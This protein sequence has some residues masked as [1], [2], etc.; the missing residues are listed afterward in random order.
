MTHLNDLTP[1]LDLRQA[2]WSE[3]PARTARMN[4]SSSGAKYHTLVCYPDGS[5]KPGSEYSADPKSGT[6]VGDGDPVVIADAMLIEH[7]NGTATYAAPLIGADDL[8]Q[9]IVLERDEGAEADARRLLDVSAAA[10]L[11]AFSIVCPGS[12]GHEG[13]RI[14][15]LAEL[16]QTIGGS[17]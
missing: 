1:G 5:I 14:E 16:E 2:L 9:A 4:T 3:R 15:V 13:L 7:L 12:G 8:A 11:I 17:P 6:I 10:G